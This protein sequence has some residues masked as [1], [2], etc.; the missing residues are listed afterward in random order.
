MLNKIKD[1]IRSLREVN[2]KVDRLE[3]KLDD[4]LYTVHLVKNGATVK[5]GEHEAITRIFTGQKMYLDTRDASLTPHLMLDG[6]WEHTFTHVFLKH[7]KPGDVVLDIGA[8]F[9]Y[10][11]IIA[12]SVAGPSG[13]LGFVDANK[14]FKPYIEKSLAVNGLRK[15]SVVSVFGV[16][17]KKG[18]MQFNILDSWASSSFMDPAAISK[19]DGIDYTVEES[20]KVDLDTV[21]SFCA[22]NKFTHANVIKLDVEGFE[23]QAIDGMKKIIS[24]S[25]D[26]HL[27][28]EFS[29]NRYKKPE[30]FYKKLSSLFVTMEHINDHTGECTVIK[31]YQHLQRLIVEDGW[32][33][34]HLHK[35]A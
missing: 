32:A 18:S 16:S 33:M 9:G 13:R 24:G 22:K 14:T 19:G 26:L 1:V 23:P 17:D 2:E 4:A 25:K 10:F 35:N 6:E 12:G 21:D 8:N 28:I 29:P 7:I 27:F 15:N 30:A 20:Y 5:T 11:G 31:D 3:R 34:L